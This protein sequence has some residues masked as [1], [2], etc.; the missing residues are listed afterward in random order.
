MPFGW[1]LR[2]CRDY[3][4]CITNHHVRVFFGKYLLEDL[5]INHFWWSIALLTISRSPQLVGPDSTPDRS[6]TWS[7]PSITRACGGAVFGDLSHLHVVCLITGEGLVMSFPRRK[8]NKNVHTTLW[9]KIADFHIL[10][11]EEE[12]KASWHGSSVL[13]AFHLTLWKYFRKHI[14]D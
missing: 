13:N 3:R 10:L 6:S 12:K 9:M 4:Y 5:A 1:A 8:L 14:K 2:Q 11:Q 7:I